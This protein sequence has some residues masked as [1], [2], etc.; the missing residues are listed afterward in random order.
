VVPL[1]VGSTTL[2][3]VAPRLTYEALAWFK[4]FAAVRMFEGF[5]LSVTGPVPSR[6]SLE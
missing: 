3:F 2:L 1:V 4:W 5:E 6:F